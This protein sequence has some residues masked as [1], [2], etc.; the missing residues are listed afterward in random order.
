MYTNGATMTRRKEKGAA[1]HKPDA[2]EEI[3]AAAAH[4]FTAFKGD[5]YDIPKDGLER[6]AEWMPPRPSQ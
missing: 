2:R 6:H 3:L 5:Y 1:L 4:L